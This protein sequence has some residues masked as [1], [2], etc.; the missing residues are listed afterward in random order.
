MNR[1]LIIAAA[2][3]VAVNPA[4][5]QRI[6]LDGGN[7][8]TVELGP[9]ETEVERGID[10][11]AV[12]DLD[13]DNPEVSVGGG[14]DI[15]IDGDDAGLDG[16]LTTDDLPLPRDHDEAPENT[17]TNAPSSPTIEED[18]FSDDTGTTAEDPG[19]PPN[20]AAPVVSGADT[21]DVPSCVDAEG[22]D[23]QRQA[24]LEQEAPDAPVYIRRIDITACKFD[25]ADALMNR[26]QDMDSVREGLERMD[27][28][29][30]AIISATWTTDAGL[31]VYTVPQPAP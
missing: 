8:T 15:A 28:A 22:F 5:A 14:V 7:R 9:S 26:L 3:L 20:P 17:P 19:A 12:I 30:D 27:I 31:I 10:G 13:R 25:G 24:F 21:T 11:N 23:L 29:L 2:V 1:P 4:F 6:E 16:A 18:S